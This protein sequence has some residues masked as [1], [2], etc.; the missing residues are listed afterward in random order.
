MNHRQHTAKNGHWNQHM[1]GKSK[2]MHSTW[3]ASY[4]EFVGLCDTP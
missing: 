3:A 1:Q 4:L 2:N